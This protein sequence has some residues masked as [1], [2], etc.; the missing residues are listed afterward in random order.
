MVSVVH[1]CSLTMR[2]WTLFWLVFTI[3]LAYYKEELAKILHLGREFTLGQMTKFLVNTNTHVGYHNYFLFV[4]ILA[5]SV[6]PASIAVLTVPQR[7]CYAWV[8]YLIILGCTLTI[9]CG[10]YINETVRTSEYQTM[11]SRLVYY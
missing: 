1:S 6:V 4:H 5:S 10:G 3:C 8:G 9:F 11:T 2:G 7:R